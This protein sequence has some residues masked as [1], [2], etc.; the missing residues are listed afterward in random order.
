M[1]DL[2][3]KRIRRRRT[4]L[5]LSIRALAR[6]V[7]LTASFLS[8]LERGQA[9]PSI[10]SLRKIADALDVP[11][12]FFFDDVQE[13]DPIVR[14]AGRARLQF[15]GS[16]VNGELLTPSSRR[17]NI[18][19]LMVEVDPKHGDVA[20][21]LPDHAEECIFVLKGSLTITYR[22]SVYELV[23]GDSIYLECSGPCSLTATGVEPAVF[24]AAM[25]PAAY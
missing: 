16:T 12:V 21:R 1:D 2:I 23:A 15:S 14:R 18:E 6:E 5:K 17:N 4:D 13:T 25:S 3:G 24:V 11:L 8:Q 19:L 7:N 22:E 20:H 10:K 9:D